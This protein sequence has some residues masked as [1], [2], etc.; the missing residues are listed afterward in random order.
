M[1][2]SKERILVDAYIDFVTFWLSKPEQTEYRMWIADHTWADIAGQAAKWLAMYNEAM[3]DSQV[4]KPW[5]FVKLLKEY[6]KLNLE[7]LQAEYRKLQESKRLDALFGDKGG[8][9]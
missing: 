5:L 3:P 6:V 2:R 7:D 8:G 4:E 1:P 9:P